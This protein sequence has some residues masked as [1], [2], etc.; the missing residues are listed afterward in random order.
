MYNPENT[1][2]RRHMEDLKDGDKFFVNGEEHTAVD[3]HYLG[4]ASYDTYI[5]YDENGEEYYS[6]DF[7]TVGI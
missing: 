4:D 3:P 6:E 7:P 5:V 2:S 1:T